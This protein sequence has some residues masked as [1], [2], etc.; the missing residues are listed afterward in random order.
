MRSS[1]IGVIRR[2]KRA[3]ESKRF[4]QFFCLGSRLP[5]PNQEY[6][7]QILPGKMHSFVEVTRVSSCA[8]FARVFLRKFLRFVAMPCSGVGFL[9]P[10]EA[11]LGRSDRSSKLGE[12]VSV[13]STSAG[14]ELRIADEDAL[15]LC[16][17]SIVAVSTGP[18]D[19]RLNPNSV[20]TYQLFQKSSTLFA[21]FLCAH[22]FLFCSRQSFLKVVLTCYCLLLFHTL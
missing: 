1:F 9:L 11:S 8:G 21:L 20:P 16:Q 7:L 15:F 12:A 14:G 2:R 13:S 6:G 19:E 22:H 18:R 10:A 17:K 4:S 5:C 3:C